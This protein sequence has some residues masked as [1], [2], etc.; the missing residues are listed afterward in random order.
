MLLKKK[1]EQK[2]NM[3]KRIICI[4]GTI[5]AGKTTLLS[6]LKKNG[7]V[8]CKEPLSKWSKLKTYSN[9]TIF[10]CFYSNPE[11]YA[12]IFKLFSLTTLQERLLTVDT[13]NKEKIFLERSIDSVKNIFQ[14]SANEN[15]YFSEFENI[16]FEKFYS[17]FNS[18][19]SLE[20]KKTIYL[21]CPTNVAMSR[22]LKRNRAGE[23]NIPQ[24]YFE[25]LR[26]KHE[27]WFKEEPMMNLTR[28][29]KDKSIEEIYSIV[30]SDI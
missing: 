30:T 26:Q 18:F 29:S 4:E 6:K 10:Q 11:I 28:I 5:A 1:I 22:C 13:K 24:T 8:T 16:I 2:L 7:Y 20:K 15:G 25:L 27:E 12:P 9:K 14:K 23:G 17:F 3:C 21:E 19:F